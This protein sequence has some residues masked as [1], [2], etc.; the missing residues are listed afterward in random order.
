MEIRIG[1]CYTHTVY[2]P[3]V[4]THKTLKG[5]WVEIWGGPNMDQL[6]TFKGVS[7]TDLS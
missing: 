5:Y 6:Y 7:A 1:S 3:C 2:G 4:V